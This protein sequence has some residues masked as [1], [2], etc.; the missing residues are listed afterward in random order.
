MLTALNEESRAKVPSVEGLTRMEVDR[1]YKPAN[2]GGI[3]WS[4]F[5]GDNDTDGFVIGGRN[6]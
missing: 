4:S 6:E 1:K 2:P 3:K 5:S